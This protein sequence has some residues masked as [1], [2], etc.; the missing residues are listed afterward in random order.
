MNKFIALVLATA[1]TFPVVGLAWGDAP[2]ED[3][4]EKAR[5][6]LEEWWEQEEREA[7]ERLKRER[8]YR[9][10]NQQKDKLRELRRHRR[11]VL[12]R[13][14]PGHRLATGAP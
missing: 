2:D 6:E 12:C 7:Q 3:L 14:D 11:N 1:L 9:T 10:Q 5:L 4:F 8:L 13:V